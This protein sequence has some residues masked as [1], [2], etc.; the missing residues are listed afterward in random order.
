MPSTRKSPCFCRFPRPPRSLPAA[1]VAVCGRPAAPTGK[2][3]VT[4]PLLSTARPSRWSERDTARQGSAK[5]A[6]ARPLERPTSR[7]SQTAGSI[8]HHQRSI[9]LVSGTGPHIG[10]AIGKSGDRTDTGGKQ[11]HLMVFGGYPGDGLPLS[12][13][14]G[15]LKRWHTA[16]DASQTP[17][18]AAP[19]ANSRPCRPRP[20]PSRRSRSRSRPTITLTLRT[21][22]RTPILQT[23]P[24]NHL[25]RPTGSRP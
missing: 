7:S 8:P 9:S 25:S 13:T 16:P 3:A 10:I 17:I 15:S 18:R 19:R 1:S 20:A 14:A 5:G 21:M 11:A 6:S 23:P 24:S 2:G 12:W 4:S 22:T